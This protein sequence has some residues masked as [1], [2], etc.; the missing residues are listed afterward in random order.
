MNEGKHIAIIGGG[1]VGLCTAHELVATG[2]TVT[3][4]EAE[5]GSSL[6]N[7]GLITPSHFVPLAAPGIVRLGLKWMF[8]PDS[9]FYIRP[10]FDAE[11]LAW[12]WH[13]N[14]ASTARRAE[15]A[16]PL[17]R[18]LSFASLALF[19]QMA[20]LPDMAFEFA[21]R[22]LLMV[23]RT[24]HGR[25]GALA[26]ARRAD[27][28]G[29][30]ARVLDARGLAA[31][32]PGVDFRVLGGVYYPD[33]AHL[34]PALFLGALRA[35][36]VAANVRF[37]ASAPVLGF[38]T[39]Q[40]SIT[41]LE[42]S[43]G[44]VRADEYVLA[45]G[46]WSPEI[47]RHLGLRLPVQP[48]KGYSITLRDPGLRVRIPMIL[49]EARIA[50][51]PMGEALRLAGTMEL[52]GMDP[53]I[54]ARRV[55]AILKAAPVYLGNLNAADPGPLAHWAGLR[56]CTPDGLPLIGRFRRYDNLIAATGHAMVGVSLA[57]VT[58]KLVA[59]IV[60]GKVPSIDMHLLRPDRY[61]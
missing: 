43:Q 40:G 48:G 5:A 32:E 18:D 39:R 47:V 61:A 7:A 35:K 13:F 25:H 11:L 57:P 27:S 51:T 24:E 2:C 54:N 55:R 31:L 26:T 45:A 46:S 22:G 38:E 50:V 10:R 59:E 29:I 1:I 17:L 16:M 15:K 36:L 52:S 41:A 58:G 20:A 34:T 4:L 28:L 9:P 56:P 14:A 49:E 33:D 44:A 12:L 21:H 3:V 6:H 23:F 37:L 60:S 53:G 19:E 8:N 42:T 30:E